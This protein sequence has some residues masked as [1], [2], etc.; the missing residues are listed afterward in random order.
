MSG[1]TCS[2]TC[3]LESLPN[4]TTRECD[5]CGVGSKLN[6]TDDACVCDV[7]NKFVANG[8]SC[9]CD[10]HL[11]LISGSCERVCPIET[12]INNFNSRT[13]DL[14]N[15]GGLNNNYKIANDD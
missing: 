8:A 11:F 14:C 13:C 4:D 7:D 10:E 9:R 6:D 5:W 1:T 2:T 15:P 3:N 12:H